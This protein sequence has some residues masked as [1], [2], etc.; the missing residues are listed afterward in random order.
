MLM[1]FLESLPNVEVV[2][3]T[4]KFSNLS[5]KELPYKT[6]CKYYPVNVYQDLDRSNN[7]NIFHT[8]INAQK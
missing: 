7:F 3:K 2:S 6:S 8:N 4:S 1:G 5:M